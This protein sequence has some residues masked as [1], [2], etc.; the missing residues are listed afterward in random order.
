ML[1][2][3]LAFL[4]RTSPISF[5]GN[6]YLLVGVGLIQINKIVG[7]LTLNVKWTSCNKIKILAS[8]NLVQW[9]LSQF[10]LPF[11]CCFDVSC[12][13]SSLL[14]ETFWESIL[15]VVSHSV[16]WSRSGSRY[17]QLPWINSPMDIEKC[18]QINSGAV[19]YVLIYCR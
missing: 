3:T 6:Q 12:I 8:T 7:H 17:T 5:H 11:L 4:D 16:I 14:M 2:L 19:C 15:A 13:V 1:C 10:Q 9:Y 18:S